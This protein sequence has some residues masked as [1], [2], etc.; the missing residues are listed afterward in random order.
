M[1]SSIVINTY[2]IRRRTPATSRSRSGSVTNLQSLPQ[3]INR[4]VSSCLKKNP[5]AQ[6]VYAAPTLQNLQWQFSA[7]T[8][9]DSLYIYNLK[10]PSRA[11]Q[12]V[13]FI[14]FLK[15]MWSVCIC[16]FNITK[17]AMTVFCKYIKRFNL[18]II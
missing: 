8:Y 10:E 4:F 2:F 16:N 18:N 9:R 7:N 6:C 13:R 17:L 5:C 3:L 15:T 12:K 11:Y 1:C 14:M